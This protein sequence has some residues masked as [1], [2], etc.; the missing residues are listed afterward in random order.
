MLIKKGVALRRMLNTNLEPIPGLYVGGHDANTMYADTYP[1]YESGN[2]Y[3]FAYTTS[4]LTAKT[5]RSMSGL[6][7]RTGTY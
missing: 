2:F 1:A 6:W 5:Q 7:V 4:L 3:S